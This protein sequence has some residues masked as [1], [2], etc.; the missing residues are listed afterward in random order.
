VGQALEH[1]VHEA[2]VAQVE[3]AGALGWMG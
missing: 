1:R 2:G 3:Q